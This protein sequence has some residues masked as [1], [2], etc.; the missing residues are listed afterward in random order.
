M[1]ELRPSFTKGLFTTLGLY[2]IAIPMMILPVV[3]PVLAFTLIPYISSALG[4]RFAH[5]R[6]RMPLAITAAVLWSA[7]QTLVLVMIMQRVASMSPMG[8]KMDGI[9]LTLII[10]I[11][12]LNTLF[13]A[14]GARHPWNDPF[15]DLQ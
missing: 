9:G 11:W 7:L 5:P 8:F 12:A 15:Q 10:G 13:T 1:R 4:S 2:T 3:G 14:L 6:E